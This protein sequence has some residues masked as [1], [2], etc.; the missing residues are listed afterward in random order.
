[1]ARR[2]HR[3]ALLPYRGG[4]PGG[5]LRLTLCDE[6][7]ESCR[8]VE[9]RSEPGDV[10]RR[11]RRRTAGRPCGGHRAVPQPVPPP[12]R[13]ARPTPPPADPA[14]G[15]WAARR[16]PPPAWWS[17]P[18]RP[19]PPAV[20]A[21]SWVV[22]DLDSGAV[23]GGCGPHE[24]GMPASVQKLLLVATVLPKLD[25]RQVVTVTAEDLNYRAGQFGRRA[26]RGRPVPGRDALARAA[27][28][29]RQRRGQRAGPARRRHA[30]VA[31]S[32][33]AMNEEAH[34]LGAGPD[35]RGHAVRPGRSGAVHQRRTTWR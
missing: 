3:G 20:S 34:R 29:L 13:P 18:A 28:Q 5:A 21:T 35:P 7:V 23:L 11:I 12:T 25:P 26:G 22:A 15:P 4:R 8:G 32:V 30:G 17:R 6:L 16:W 10:A 27:A 19:D 1:M 24:Y 31:G 33:R 2:G 14:P 9:C